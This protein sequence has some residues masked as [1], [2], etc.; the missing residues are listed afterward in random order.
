[1]LT[2]P[3][4]DPVAFSIGPL[5]VHWYG[6]MYLFGFTL[7]W[8]LGLRRIR[9]PYSPLNNTEQLSDLLF[10]CAMGVILGGRLGYVLFYDLASYIA[11]PLNI[12]QV[13]RGGMSF[14]GGLIGVLL[15]V[16]LYSRRIQCHF[17]AITDF[18]APL[19]PIA[20]GLGRIGNFINGE[21]WGRPTDLP[22]GMIFPDPAAG[23]I[24]RHPS[25]LY[26]ALAEGIVLF[27]LLWLYSRKPRPMMAV[28]G[29]FLMGYGVL[30][31]FTEFFRTP[32]AH[33]GF[34]AFDWLTMGQV[35]SIPMIGAGVILM[36]L[37]YRRAAK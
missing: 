13:W 4:I 36:V 6:L 5:A 10:Y 25:Q 23:Y 17:F 21:L 26:Q 8:W 22:W 11:H 34:I 16:W 9:A 27:L 20:L 28:S 7:A 37:A 35:L 12:L 31:L 30:R 33:L 14:H 24:A 29:L 19:I 32:D 3:S 18:I 15:A 1:M 2:Y